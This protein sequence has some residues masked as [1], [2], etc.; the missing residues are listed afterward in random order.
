MGL[1][2]KFKKKK[3][4]DESVINTV[5][6]AVKERT[7][8]LAIGISAVESDSV[9]LFDSKFGG[10]PYWPADM[11]YP[12][13]ED[14]QNLF[15]LAQLNFDNISTED[16]P[17]PQKGILQFFIADD[18]MTGLDFDHP[19]EQKNFRVVYHESV[20]YTVTEADVEALGVCA[21]EDG[22]YFPFSGQYALSFEKKSDYINC[23]AA[24]YDDMVSEI[25][26]ELYPE[27]PNDEFWGR[28]S[29]DECM[30][31]MDLLSDESHKILGFPSFTQDD[32]RDDDSPYNTLL[33]QIVSDNGIMWGDCGIANF[34]INIEDLKNLDF[35]K[36]M[37]NWDCC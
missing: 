9:G 16:T 8:C 28:L 27:R 22:E 34:F 7:E 31:L 20:N 32:P 14:G 30:K 23:T 36:V 5:L 1:F 12:V 21:V 35:S 15:L 29:E 13:G 37:Y 33:L 25:C 6:A 11:N 19:D 24:A 4:I 2:S 17:L 26:D 3:N 18:D 10:L